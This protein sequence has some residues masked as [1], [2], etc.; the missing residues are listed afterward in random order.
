M[1]SIRKRALLDGQIRWQVDYRDGSGKRRHKQFPTRRDADAFMVRARAEVAAGTHMPDSASITIAQAANLWL[2]R[3][4]R[5]GLERTTLF[6]YRQHVTLHILP[7]IG[8]T[9]L[10]RLTVPAV[11]AFADQLLGRGRSRYLTKR[12]LGSLSGIVREAQR[13]GLAATNNVRK[14]APDS[15]KRLAREITRPM[16]PTREELRAIIN[17]TPDRW[18]PL[19]LTAI[20][21]GLRASELRGLTWADVDLKAGKLHVCRRVDRFG[22]FGPPKSKAGSRDIPLSPILLNTLK[23]W[24]LACPKGELDLVFPTGAGNVENHG[25]ILL[26]VFWPIQVAAGVVNQNGRAKYSL[27]ALRHA[28]ALWIDQGLGP[29]RI[30]ALMGHASIQQTFDQYGY[31]LETREGD[32]NALA[33]IEARLLR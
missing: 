27:H 21:T 13:R 11:H 19:I 1:A 6:G 14:A 25:N 4:E 10:A 31:L 3:G 2:A 16:M 7:F 26:R 9:K 15:V 20:F 5:D 30:Q 12:V 24:R 28:A 33:E 17:A 18:R 8:A 23:A 29:K 32:Q 22:R